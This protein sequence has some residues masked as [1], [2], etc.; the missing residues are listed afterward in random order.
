MKCL[1]KNGI[2]EGIWEFYD[3]DGSLKE[4]KLYED[5]DLI[6]VL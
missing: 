3:E 4:R 6:K 5:G 1:Y 2:L